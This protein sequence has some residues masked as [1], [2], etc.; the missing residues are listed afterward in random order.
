MS[1]MA[2]PVPTGT[3]VLEGAPSGYGIVDGQAVC[4]DEWDG[5]PAERSRVARWLADRGGDALVLS[6]DVHSSWVFEGGTQPG[7]PP[8]RRSS[9]CP[10]VS[11]TPMGRQ[12]PSGLAQG[13]E[14]GRSTVPRRPGGSSSSRGATS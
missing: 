3:T 11:S 4:V 10:A 5:Y 12:L 2:L 1:P 6:G 13:R 14:R 8:S 9:S 7:S